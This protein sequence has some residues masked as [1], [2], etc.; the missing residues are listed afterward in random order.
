[1]QRVYPPGAFA[2]KKEHNNEHKAKHDSTH[3][4]NDEKHNP[5]RYMVAPGSRFNEAVEDRRQGC[6][7]VEV[8][9]YANEGCFDCFDAPDRLERPGFVLTPFIPE[10]AMRM[11]LVSV[12]AVHHAL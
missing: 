4:A 7:V 8:L 10:W 3:R 6:Q 9:G 12:L 5:R 1:M 2:G 11:L